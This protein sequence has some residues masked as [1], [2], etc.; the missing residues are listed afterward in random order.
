MLGWLVTTAGPGCSDWFFCAFWTGEALGG[1][2]NGC[3][4]SPR[5]L[6]RLPSRPATGPPGAGGGPWPRGRA[7]PASGWWRGTLARSWSQRRACVALS[8]S[9]RKPG[10]G[11]GSAV[12]GPFLVA[13]HVPAPERPGLA[14]CSVRTRWLRGVI[15]CE[16]DRVGVHRLRWSHRAGLARMCTKCRWARSLPARA[17]FSP[18][19]RLM[20]LID[21]IP[22]LYSADWLAQPTGRLRPDD[23]TP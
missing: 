5:L 7:L 14:R 20:H 21:V 15:Q 16:L 18:M 11:G 10:Q 1:C 17:R 6:P 2:S 22:S 12:A 13:T 9:W 23:R 8:D 4:L 3:L 19:A